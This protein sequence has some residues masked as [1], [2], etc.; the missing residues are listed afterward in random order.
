[1][2]TKAV[3]GV[4]VLAACLAP[5][6]G[7]TKKK[8]APKGTPYV[9]CAKLLPAAAAN[10]ATGGTL[11]LTTVTLGG[12]NRG[13][14]HWVSACTYKSG[15]LSNPPAGA[16]GYSLTPADAASRKGF[17]TAL[18]VYKTAAMR[19]A[20]RAECQPGWD[21]TTEGFG[22]DTDF[23]QVV[24][25]LGANSFQLDGYLFVLTPKY[26]LAVGR[27]GHGDAATVT[28]L[29]KAVVARLH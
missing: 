19:N 2:A 5:I 18:A 27:G 6:A 13:A 10:A 17:A 25:P 15:T 7:A 29:G 8:P 12:A 21:A 20:S 9:N 28:A 1:V 24:Y 16:I 26:L 3:L 11:D 14:G 22:P 4:L 23:C